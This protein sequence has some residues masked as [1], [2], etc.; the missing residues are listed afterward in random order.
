MMKN[1]HLSHLYKVVCVTGHIEDPV[2]L[3]GKSRALCLG[4]RLPPSFI[5][6]VF[7]I[8]GLNKLYGCM[9]SP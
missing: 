5:H 9:F 2:P 8:T 4:G 3:I 7:I 1:I 6:Q